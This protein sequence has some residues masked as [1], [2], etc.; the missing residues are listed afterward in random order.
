MVKHQS[1]QNDSPLISLGIHQEN[2]SLLK[3]PVGP[4]RQHGE[5]YSKHHSTQN[6]SLLRTT[7]CHSQ[8][9]TSYPANPPLLAP[10]LLK[11]LYFARLQLY[12]QRLL[13]LSRLNSSILRLF[14]FTI[15]STNTRLVT[16]P[17]SRTVF[18]H[19]SY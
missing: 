7:P 19:F 5:N 2:K 10:F 6:T 1:A 9:I 18:A 15:D 14:K 12:N 3:T 11:W 13:R 16:Y 8:A 4:R 17:A